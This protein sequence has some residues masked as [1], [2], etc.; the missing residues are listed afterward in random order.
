MVVFPNFLRRIGLIVADFAV[1][2]SDNSYPADREFIKQ[3]A[4]K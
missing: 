2:P 1:D 4:Y 3:A